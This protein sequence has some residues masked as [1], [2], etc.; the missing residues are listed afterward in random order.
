MDYEEYFSGEEEDLVTE[1]KAYP[2]DFEGSYAYYDDE[3][4]E[5]DP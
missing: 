2:S 1:M 5:T 3:D 4:T